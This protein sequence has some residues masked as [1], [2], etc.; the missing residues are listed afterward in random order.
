MTELT[1]GHIDR[2]DYRYIVTDLRDNAIIGE[3]PLQQVSYSNELSREGAL[4]AEIQV[5]WDTMVYQLKDV[6][7]PGR[8]GLYVLRN[9]NP[10]WGGMIWK[11]RYSAPSRTLE[12][13]ASTFESYLYKRFQ[14]SNRS[15]A[16]TDQLQIARQ[17]TTNEAASILMTVDNKT[18]GRVRE[19]NMYRHEFKTVG[20]ELEQLGNLIDGFDWNVEITRGDGLTLNRILRFYYPY[21]GVS[22]ENTTLSF[23]YPGSIASV[24]FSEDADGGANRMWA[25]GAG[26][27]EEQITRLASD[28][29]GNWPPLHESRSYKSVAQYPTLQAHADSDLTRLRTPIEVAEIDV[30]A[31]IEPY[32]GTYGPGDWARFVFKDEYFTP[33]VTM[34]MRIIGYTVRVDDEGLESI[35][36]VVNTERAELAPGEYEEDD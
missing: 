15:W 12:I 20:E 4:S 17:I 18:S 11:R 33:P 32:L 21:R 14:R 10:I 7:V 22:K 23:E 31:D 16:S 1:H 27:A 2:V 34:F 29:A 8:T 5:N 25:I 35:S 26:E 36:L 9:G 28:T 3:L 6:T 24:S 30:R 13:E 19:R